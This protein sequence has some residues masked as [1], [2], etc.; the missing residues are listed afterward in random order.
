M[1][2]FS[3]LQNHMSGRKLLLPASLLFSAL[4][5]IAGMAPFVLIWFIIREFVTVGTSSQTAVN[6]YA[7]WAAGLAVASVLLYFVAL[8]LSHLAAFRVECNM[9][10]YAMK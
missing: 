1:N 2:T 10:R 4:S 5:A 7:W 3:K 8:S 9:R 6:T